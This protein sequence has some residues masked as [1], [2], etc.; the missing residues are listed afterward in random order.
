MA[1]KNKAFSAGQEMVFIYAER[2]GTEVKLMPVTRFVIP[3]W[4]IIPIG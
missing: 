1:S 2:F 4:S 3:L